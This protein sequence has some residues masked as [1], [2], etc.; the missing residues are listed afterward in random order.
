MSRARHHPNLAAR[1]GRWSAGHWKT[2]TF[3]WLDRRD[4][5]SSSP[6]ACDHEAAG[7]P[8]LVPTGQASFGPV[9]SVRPPLTLG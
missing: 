4:A 3:G 2:A 8:E 7:R 6:P 9:V 1:M 5:R